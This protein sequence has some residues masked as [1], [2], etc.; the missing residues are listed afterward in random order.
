MNGISRYL[1]LLA[2][3]LAELGHE[4]SVI[5]SRRASGPR[6]ASEPVRVITIPA[7]KRTGVAGALTNSAAFA[8]ALA[9]LHKKRRV[10]VV[11]WTNLHFEGLVD[12]IRPIAPHVTRVSTIQR[13]FRESVGPSASPLRSRVGERTRDLLEEVALRR[14][15][16][17]L[18][19]TRSH[20]AEVRRR[21]GSRVP[22]AITPLGTPDRVL[23]P[24]D[25]ADALRFLFVGR[26]EARKGVDTLIAAFDAYLNSGAPT[27]ELVLCGEDG[28]T[29]GGQSF[30]EHALSGVAP[31]TREQIRATGFVPDAGL[32]ELYAQA[33]LV[34]VPSRYESFGLVI[35]EAMQQGLPIVA[36]RAGG[37]PEVVTSGVDGL[38]VPP[39]DAEA[40]ASALQ[41]LVA[42]P[43]LRQ[44][45]G[46]RGRETWDSRYSIRAMAER[47]VAAYGSLTPG[48]V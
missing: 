39:D 10:S 19:S 43:N 12:A 27:A 17:L 9:A 46:L 34:V 32:L 20:A 4:V 2:P 1:G 11:E 3:E 25:N 42:E 8:R 41:R 31:A 14:S 26:L 28:R 22:I 7:T 6:D 48:P 47:T 35:P 30:L 38:L 33:T 23:M 13:Q 21:V 45:L 44:Q 37:V 24:R 36:C 18:C 16:L 29:R 15:D 40:L 5:T